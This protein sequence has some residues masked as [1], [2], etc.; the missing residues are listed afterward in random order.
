VKKGFV[1]MQVSA[2]VGGAGVGG[3]GDGFGLFIIPFPKCLL[4]STASAKRLKKE[5]ARKVIILE[6]FMVDCCLGSPI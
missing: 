4:F 6:V 1:P 5:K 2:Q 3:E